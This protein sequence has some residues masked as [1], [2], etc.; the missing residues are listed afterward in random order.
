MSKAF[1]LGA[2][3]LV[4]VMAFG[5]AAPRSASAQTTAD[6]QA[7]IA[8]LLAQIQALQSQLGGQQSGGVAYNFTRD[9][10]LGSTGN[11]VMQ[12]QQFLN[13]KGFAV[14]ASGAGSPG[15]ESTYFGNLTKAALAKY[16]ASVGISPAVGYFGPKTRAYINSLGV[17]PGPG[18]VVPPGSGL[19]LSLA[20][21][22]PVGVSVPK[23]AAGIA[24]LKFNVAGSG[25]V[26]SLVFKRMG[27]GA[28]AD[29]ASAGFYLYDGVTRLTSGRSLNSTTHEV[30]FLNLGLAVSG[31]K[32]L[33]LVADISSSATAS[34]QDWFELVSAT[35]N[36]A[37]SGSLRGNLFSIAGQA[38]GTITATSGAA[39]TNPKVGQTG[40]K[41]AEFKLSAGSTED[42]NIQ[43]LALTE[44]GSIANSNLSN[45]ILKQGGNT[46]A[47]ASA[48]GAKDLI[49]F[50]LSSPFLLEKGQERTFEVWADIA[51]ATRSSDTIV[52]YFDSK[53]DI[54]AIGKTY[55]FPVN[56]D[57]TALDT[58][59]EGDTLTVAGGD[60]TITFNGPI[61]G[62][63]ARRG[64]DVPVFDF[65][66][67]AK[68]NIEIRNLRFSVAVTGMQADDPYAD[69]KI[70]DVD[71]NSVVTSA[72]DVTSSTTSY[73]FT[74]VLNVS[75]GQTK[76][77]K[78]TVDVDAD[79]DD[80]DTITVT[81]VAFS[82]GDIKNLDNNT[83]VDTSV[84]VPNANVAGNLQTVKVPT[85]DVQLAATPASQTYVKGSTNVDL[86]GLSFR[87]IADNIRLN[88][89]KITASTTSG[90]LTSGEVTNLALYDGATRVSDVKSLDTTALT[91]TFDNL[92]LTLTKGDTKVLTLRGNTATDITDGDVFYFKIAAYTTDV[93]AYDRD[94]NSATLS[95]VNAN[96]GPTV[97]HTIAANGDVT[98]VKAADDS[99]SEAGIVV[100]GGE[101][102]L[103]KFRFTSANEAMTV[104]KMQVL[105]NNTTSNTATTSAAADEV[106]VVKLYD[107]ATQIGSAAGYSVAFSGD[108]SG[109]AT[110][111][112]LGWVIP[113][114]GSKTLT[115]KGALN[116]ISGGADSGASVYVH[117][118]ASNFE[119]QG[120]TAKD[121][122]ITAAAGNE[123]V[124]FKTRPTLSVAAGDT[125]LTNGL[126]KVMRFTVAADS[127]EQV[128]WK[129]IQLAVSMTS[130]TM[131]AASANPGTTGTVQIKDVASGSNLNIATAFS[132]ST[133]AA[134]TTATITG[135]NTGYVALI[136]NTEEVIPA[137]GSKDY[138]VYLTF[139]DVPSTSA[140]AVVNL[141]RAETTL[142]AAT[143]QAT[144][145]NSDANGV[146]N[147][148]PSFIWSDY[149]T[150]G[151]S[152]ST[153]TDWS[154]GVYVKTLPSTSFTISKS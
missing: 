58:T 90:T 97:S 121:T 76:H 32:T 3:A 105:V 62:D 60:V 63:I 125:T 20:S 86:V 50:V 23:G 153:A 134:S 151:H 133:A 14:A 147:G 11:D 42:I 16:Q 77:Y 24:M 118:S 115:V 68:N 38:V 100:A 109:I 29:F 139:A 43:R 78:A 84:I 66:L 102:I 87:A 93:V 67:A 59:A 5:V 53:S 30:S 52:L 7:Q 92:N 152:E 103:G 74:D 143:L 19:V 94:G 48:V 41:I 150:V 104:N 146:I 49:S 117:V 123:K 108:N 8:A 17:T 119:A 61:S 72:F 137:G 140:S 126:R 51:G 35:G 122:T 56:P 18:P 114:D 39:P 88:S 132:G 110:I 148:S 99:D 73:V 37:P 81:L 128:A 15:N 120:Q 98:V 45:F 33:T 113:K 27:V 31:V 44:G 95:G 127:A 75:A 12:L 111:E 101:R 25:T 10:T 130:A 112:N 82:A 26:D 154:N 1:K 54:Y 116:S 135:G 65:N 34:N 13:G 28:T 149:S 4:A 83:N 80:N 40:V 96:S 70:W 55:G 22:N 138:D 36:P 71:T 85:L 91:A 142:V 124:V 9:L 145:E 107:G 6:L 89:V 21:D 57:I 131:S 136:L 69:F 47:T 129:K 2:I 144:V 106:P 79:A 64:Q 46:L 141:H